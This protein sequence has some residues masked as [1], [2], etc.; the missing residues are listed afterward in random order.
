MTKVLNKRPIAHDHHCYVFQ[1][2]DRGGRWYLYFYDQERQ[3][4][5]RHSLGRIAPNDVLEAERK[6]LAKY[7]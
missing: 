5:H 2:G 6:G 1:D 3:S 4:R 7:I